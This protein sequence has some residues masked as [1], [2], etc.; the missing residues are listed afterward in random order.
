MS[1]ENR[2]VDDL[3]DGLK[4]LWRAA[5]TTVRKWDMSRADKA[6]DKTISRVGRVATSVTRVVS[7]EVARI[8]GKA[9]RAGAAHCD[10]REPGESEPT[11]ESRDKTHG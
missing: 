6:L 8:I 3:K 5:R 7:D 10:A 9:P 4:L 11:A 2:P 1:E